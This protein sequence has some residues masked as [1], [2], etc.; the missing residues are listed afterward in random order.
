M[1]KFYTVATCSLLAVAGLLAQGAEVSTDLKRTVRSEVVAAQG[2]VRTGKEQIEKLRAGYEAGEY[3]LFLETLESEY[4]QMKASEQ[5][6]EFVNMRNLP[7]MN[8]KEQAFVARWEDLSQQLIEE[9]NAQLK[10]ACQ[11]AN[12]DNAILVQRVDSVT[13]SLP[14]EQKE[15]LN[16]LSALRFKTPDQALTADERALIEIDLASEFKMLHLDAQYAEQPFSDRLEKQ[17]VL[18]MDML[19]QM[20]AAAQSFEDQKLK[21]TVDAAGAGLDLWQA[22]HLDLNELRRLTPTTELEKK[23]VTILSAYKTKEGDLYQQE[24]AKFQN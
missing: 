6:D 15:A 16:A 3:D 14:P 5:W 11:E 19:K 4:Q 24:V 23:I 12:A 7:P 17:I 9:R 10:A 8:E 13:T 1:K 2:D 22:R 18:K 20:Q 21:K